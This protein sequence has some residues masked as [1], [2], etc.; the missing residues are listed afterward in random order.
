MRFGKWLVIVILL[1]AAGA[2]SPVEQ[3]PTRTWSNPMSLPDE[4]E[5]YGLGD[6]FIFSFNGYYYLYVSTRDTDA[7]VKVWSSP[8]LMD[9]TYRG[10][11]T[12][13]PVTTAAY[14]PEVRYWNGKFYMY[15][16]PAGNGHYVLESETPV[17]PFRVVTDNFG[18]TIDASTFVD[19]D[20]TWYFYYAGTGGIDAAPMD[21]PLSV[22]ATGAPTGAFMDGWTEGATVFKRNGLYYMTYTGNHVFSNGY[23]INAAVSESPLG[24]FKPFE[25]NP[26]LVRTEGKTVG[27]GHNSLV[28]GPDLDS[29]YMIYH[30]LEGPGIVGPLRHM[31]MDRLFWDGNRFS[32]AGPTDTPQPAPALPVFFD[33]FE[34]DK[35]GKAWLESGKGNWSIDRDKGAVVQAGDTTGP[36]MIRTKSETESGFTAEFYLR[37]ESEAKA[38]S[39]IGAVFSYKD[40]KNYGAVWLNPKLGRMELTERSGGTDHILGEADLPKDFDYSQWHK[41]RIEHAPVGNV[42]NANLHV[43]I[44]EM[45]KYAGSSATG[46]GAIGYAAVGL[47]VC[48]GYVAYNNDVNGSSDGRYYQPLPGQVQ[49][50]HFEEGKEGKTYGVTQEADVDASSPYRPGTMSMESDGN[51]GY[52]LSGLL[53]GDWANYLVNTGES[54]PYS[55]RFRIRPLSESVAFQL[56]DQD[57]RE[58]AGFSAAKEEA[59]EWQ[60]VSSGEIMLPAGQQRW[61]LKITG[62]TLD[63]DWF[64]V[65]RY[66]SVEKWEDNF[67]DGNDFG[68]T[69]FEG[70]W[71][72]KD[73][74]LRA[75]SVSPAKSLTGEPGW[76]DYSVQADLQRMENEGRAGLLVRATEPANGL[77]QNQNRSDFVRGYYIYADAEGL[78]LDKINYGIIPLKSVAWG[79]NAPGVDGKFHLKVSV[80]GATIEVYTGN[81]SESV[82]SYT[83]RSASPFLQGR[84]G[85]QSE[86]VAVRIDRIGVDPLH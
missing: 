35:L 49:A 10:L 72:V 48:F 38:E 44:D 25:E 43:Y 2:C 69:R 28:T 11:C 21:S 84:I 3:E 64:R 31:N 83:D 12:E 9:W 13:D 57:N 22:T 70:M 36:A 46:G 29:T 40:E 54:A 61:K 6:P 62:G 86:D 55:I 52:V 42:G 60:T 79:T 39:R 76:S 5:E 80:R 82:L 14:A 81:S 58:I 17:G 18:R 67:D 1:L 37:A 23:R 73:G 66:Q 20:G 30:N 24:P 85:L 53:A 71:S 41:I 26:V 47:D 78:H 27:L 74:E 45:Q 8:D 65:E 7:G 51:D 59:G 50:V 34:R 16:S 33:R 63:L 77:D 75:S 32:V 68:W 56:V 19:D 15:T 4:W